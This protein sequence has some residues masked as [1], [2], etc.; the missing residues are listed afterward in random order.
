[1]RSDVAMK[2]QTKRL[3]G[4]DFPVV[5]VMGLEL[6]D[7]PRE[8]IVTC[9]TE[10][11]R[12]RG[13]ARVINANAHCVTLSQ[14]QLWMRG[15]FDQ[16]EIAFCDG[17][18][19]QLAS[20]FLT[21]KNLHRTTPPEWIG[22]MLS[23]LGD[24][25]NVFWLGGEQDVA[26]KAA[27]VFSRKYGCRTA[28]VQHG[29]FDVTPG[30]PEAESV[31]EKIVAAKPSV[32]L[33]NMGMPR[34]ER[35]LWDNWNRLPPLVAITAGALV[36]HAAGRVSRPPRW[37]ANLGLEWLVRLSREPKRLWRRYLLGLPCFGVYVM[38]WRLSALLGKK[39]ASSQEV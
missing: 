13:A 37:V 5:E 16:A 2:E 10:V 32:L 14:K 17:A 38:R 18:G 21:G 28:G 12:Q 35:W 7:I 30:S 20:V 19:V 8:D 39:T 36:D 24:A 23:A 3:C 15:L 9:L 34:Q 25:A 31:I 29:F 33:L 27:A 6:M 22:D 26:E 4:R 1:M 11:V